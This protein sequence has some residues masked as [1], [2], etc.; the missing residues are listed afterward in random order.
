MHLEYKDSGIEGAQNETTKGL[1]FCD[2]GILNGSGKV[3][4][5]GTDFNN[6][7]FCDEGFENSGFQSC[8]DSFENDQF[9]STERNSSNSFCNSG[10]GSDGSG[11][12]SFEN[13]RFATSVRYSISDFCNSG[14]GDEWKMDVSEYDGINNG[15]SDNQTENGSEEDADYWTE[16]CLNRSDEYESWRNM[17]LWRFMRCFGLKSKDCMTD[18]HY[19]DFYNY[20]EWT[21]YGAAFVEN[22]DEDDDN[23]SDDGCIRSDEGENCQNL[24][25]LNF[26]RLRDLTSQA[27]MTDDHY[28][29]F[30]NYIEWTGYGADFNEAGDS[31]DLDEKSEQD[32]D[33]RKIARGIKR[34]HSDNLSNDTNYRRQK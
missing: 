23:L 16:G 24:M 6:N 2:K 29:D 18:D 11:N 17:M 19:E 9:K 26:M 27:D 10:F 33:D 13:D 3:E 15:Y 25:L 30:R 4:Q 1:E 21:G 5:S 12:E 20:I 28:E 8:N 34:R 14:F 22:C 32:N 31:S 7:G